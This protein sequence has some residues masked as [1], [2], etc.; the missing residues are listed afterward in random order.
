MLN[1]NTVYAT[2][3]VRDI[4]KAM[5][6]YRDTLGLET[7]VMDDPGLA[8]FN[9]G[10]SKVFIYRSPLAGNY[11]G[12]VATWVIDDNLAGIVEELRTRGITFE[13]MDNENMPRLKR[14]GDIHAIDGKKVAWFKDP[15]GNLL[16]LY[17][18]EE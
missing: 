18:P 2:I 15:D 14:D 7:F 4:D 3:A 5:V 16:S 10:D 9:S 12:T 1:H 6:F 17:S 11:T 8:A 13:H